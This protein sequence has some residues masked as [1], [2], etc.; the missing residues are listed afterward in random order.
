MNITVVPIYAGILGLMYAALTARTIMI[1]R[2][3]K[4]GVG[5]EG[6]ISLDRAVRA[7]AN[8]GEYVPFV[9]LLMLCAELLGG[10]VVLHIAGIAL[11]LGR[12]VHAVGIS[13]EP[14]DLRFRVTGMALTLLALIVLS[15]RLIF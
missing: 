12:A 8:F 13:R 10:G 5:S 6:N 11:I 4:A 14:E 2:S 3:S 9:L 7:H 15:I 1:R